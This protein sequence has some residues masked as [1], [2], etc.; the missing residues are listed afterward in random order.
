MGMV[1]LFKKE[2]TVGNP[3]KQKNIKNDSELATVHILGY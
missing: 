2:L 1:Q 3:D